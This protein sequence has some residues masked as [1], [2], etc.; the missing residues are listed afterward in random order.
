MCISVDNKR[1]FF[2]L[3]DL[4]N[5]KVAD[6]IG[7]PEFDLENHPNARAVDGVERKHV[8]W[9]QW[10]SAW[11]RRPLLRRIGGCQAVLWCIDGDECRD[12]HATLRGVVTCIGIT[13]V[14]QLEPCL[15]KAV[16]SRD[17]SSEKEENKDKRTKGELKCDNSLS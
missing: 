6:G 15:Q 9:M 4:A 13:K 2:T 17:S 16:T 3:E 11:R 7:S 8:S 1:A 5:H 14:V 10:I 12:M